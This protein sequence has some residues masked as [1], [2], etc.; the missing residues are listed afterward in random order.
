[1]AK[2]VLIVD[3]LPFV[4]KTLAEIL[5]K[6]HYNVVGEAENGHEA[7]ALFQRLKPDVVTLDMVMPQISGLE[8][9]KRIFK[10]DKN[11]RVIIIS[12][13]GQE[14][15]VVEAISLG[16]CDYIVKPFSAVDVVRTVE[17]AL[18]DEEAMNPRASSVTRESKTGV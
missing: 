3:D 16:A 1:M 9:L 17:R 12:A 18:L 6:A 8:T 11:A 4:R 15:L 13:L 7:L 2:S 10:V 14:N 5:T